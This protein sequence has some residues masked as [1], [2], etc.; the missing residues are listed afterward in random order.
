MYINSVKILQGCYF[1]S[2]N[3]SGEKYNQAW[4][5]NKYSTDVIFADEV[6]I[7]SALAFDS[8]YDILILSNL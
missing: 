1:I 3:V 6:K 4:I 7:L 8:I 2:L 5:E